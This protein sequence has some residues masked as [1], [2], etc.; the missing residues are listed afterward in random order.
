MVECGSVAE[1]ERHGGHEERCLL[2][3]QVRTGA[4][5]LRMSL[6]GA[7]ITARVMMMIMTRAS[8]VEAEPRKRRNQHAHS[9]NALRKLRGES[10][11]ELTEP[12]VA[13]DMHHRAGRPRDGRV[14]RVTARLRRV[15]G[16]HVRDTRGILQTQSVLQVLVHRGVRHLANGERHSS[17]HEYR[18]VH[19]SC[20]GRRQ[21]DVLN[22]TTRSSRVSF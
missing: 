18:A 20:N 16:L 19:A 8:H 3:K 13:R 11:V 9:R 5:I 21:H 6:C 2:L 1:W 7:G 22:R 14:A 12:R 17:P 4:D 15:E 10:F